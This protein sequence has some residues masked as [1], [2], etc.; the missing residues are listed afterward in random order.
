MSD[1]ISFIQCRGRARS[2]DSFYHIVTYESK[3][4]QFLFEFFI[5][6]ILFKTRI[7]LKTNEKIKFLKRT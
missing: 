6:N 1:E 7:F 4:H 2:K 3:T 5:Q